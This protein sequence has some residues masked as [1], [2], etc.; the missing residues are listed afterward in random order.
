MHSDT[1][2]SVLSLP[3]SS[4]VLLHP[5]S[6]PGPWG[7]GDLGPAAREFA[8]WLGRAGQRVWQVLPLT[9][10]GPTGSPYASPSA[11]AG[12]PLLLS[13]DDLIE[14]GLLDA[15][16]PQLAEL[17][18]ASLA[19]PDRVDH[20]LQHR[21]KGA[22]VH[23]AARA[24]LEVADLGAEL[25]ALRES[26]TWL[27]AWVDFAAR[28]AASGGAPHWEWPA[29]L[30]A[31]P[32][33]RAVQEM[34]QLLFRRQMA[35]LRDVARAEGVILLGDV[36][37]FVDQD[38]ADTYGRPELFLLNAAG[39]P[40]VVAGVQPDYFSETGQKWGN[41]LYDWDAAAAE[42]YAWWVQRFTS[43][44]EVVDSVRID[45]FRGFEACWA[46]P[47]ADP[48]ARGGRWTPGP[49]P[50][51]FEALA[52]ELER[53][54]PGGGASL[55]LV[56]ED[57]GII[58][59]EVEA[60]RDG[61]GLPGMRVLHFAFDG[62]AD[63]PHLPANTS[64]RSVVYA[65]TH[66][67]DTTVGWYAA[68][69]DDRRDRVRRAL[70]VSGE[71]IAWDLIAHVAASPAEL[72]VVTVQDVLSLGSEARMNT[73]GTTEGNWAWRL[74]PGQLTDA[75]ADRLAGVCRGAGR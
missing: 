71:D 29:D 12:N 72:C 49:G 17:R 48:D 19:S 14:D 8:R 41:P 50:G 42:G 13:L 33:E 69:P 5:T 46:V 66:D 54:E 35:R 30:Q 70:S 53:R 75:D 11:F 44:L 4:G 37:I 62:G 39:R 52:A 7:M 68:S 40:E 3:R 31:D 6:L 24:A 65:G 59:D 18:E 47:E 67:N 73:P 60:L 38:S 10:V 27:G 22:L 16:D 58:T 23:R 36:P 57:L 15:A 1:D 34:L 56:A 25:A 63:N 64:A 32:T 45:H 20:G 21:L 74:R 61:L 43:L 9:P 51:P 2:S 26:T 28:K 55:P